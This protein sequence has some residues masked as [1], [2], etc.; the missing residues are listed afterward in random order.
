MV[1]YP[2]MTRETVYDKAFL[3]KCLIWIVAV[4]L[5]MKFTGGV[6]AAVFPILAMFAISYNN[7]VNLFFIL[8]MM[9]SAQ[10]GNTYFFTKGSESLICIR[11]T[12]C[13]IALMMMTHLAGRKKSN[14]LTP[15]GGVMLYVLWEFIIS[16]QGYAPIISYLKLTLFV[17]IFA[18]MFAVANEVIMSGS[19]DSRR[20]RSVVIA[21]ACL[22]LIGSVLT[23]PFPGISLMGFGDYDSRIYIESLFRGMCMHSQAMGPT[24]TAFA[25][26]IFADLV[27]SVRRMDKLYL[28]MTICA[29]IL[30]YKTSS[31]TAMGTYVLSMGMVGILAMWARGVPG[32]WKSKISTG[33]WTCVVLFAL[34]VI[35]VPKYRQAAYTFILKKHG[36]GTTFESA[37][38][39]F[40]NV[41]SSRMGTMRS[42]IAAFK[43]K[44]LQ[45][46]GFQVTSDMAY[47]KGGPITSY[48][49]APIEKGVWITAVL[50]EGGVVGLILFG[51]FLVVAFFILV[52]RRAYITASTLFTAA[53]TNLGEFIVFSMTYSGGLVWAT[54]FASAVLDAQRLREER[55]TPT[56]F[57]PAMYAPLPR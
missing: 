24:A 21:F 42:S 37:D 34:V 1:K 19:A 8:M 45:G 41:A 22:F 4:A 18:A 9:T 51:G 52:Q 43:E 13:L 28:A 17:I 27:M 7:P 3:K 57:R 50:E 38:I 23:I 31:R 40:G 48:L 30:I 39:T 35:V 16:G 11:G 20:I 10:V 46:N 29:P 12:L 26:M 44:P 14:I 15:I 53:V 32:R 49:S 47:K 55:R 25:V 6:S 36:E 33:F 56:G 5:S 54:I 2:P